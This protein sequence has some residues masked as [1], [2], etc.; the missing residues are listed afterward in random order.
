MIAPPAAPAPPS[1]FW[2]GFIVGLIAGVLF[3]VLLFP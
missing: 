2:D 1:R 3:V